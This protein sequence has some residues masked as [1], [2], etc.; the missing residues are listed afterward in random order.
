M[1]QVY[2]AGKINHILRSLDYTLFETFAK[3]LNSIRTNFLS[4][5]AE[6][7]E[8]KIPFHAFYSSEFAGVGFTHA[9]IIGKSALLASVKNFMFDFLKRF[10]LDGI[11]LL[12]SS[13]CRWIQ[14]AKDLVS[15]LSPEMWESLFPAH[16][17]DTPLKNISSLPSAVCKLQNY[18]TKEF[19]LLDFNNRISL[20]KT[21]SSE[22]AAFFN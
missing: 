8:T 21:N 22:F 11:N 3:K 7:D 6:I 4:D 12:T 18:L 13:N 19:K 5:L 15:S 10:P 17:K 16:L 2:I 14:S 20:A 1:L 9:K